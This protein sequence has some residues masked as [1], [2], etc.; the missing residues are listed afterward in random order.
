[1][2]GNERE[3]IYNYNLAGNS[4]EHTN[5]SK[6]CD[7]FTIIKTFQV[8]NSNFR[9]AAKYTFKL[10]E[11][12]KETSPEEAIALYNEAS[13]YYECHAD[14]YNIVKCQIE[15][16]YLHIKA[17][18]YSEAA[19]LFEIAGNTGSDNQLLRFKCI[20]YFMNAI[21]CFLAISDIDLA[22][23]KME[24]YS[25]TSANFKQWYR[26]VKLND[27][28]ITAQSGKLQSFV[29][30]V[31]EF[32]RQ[33]SLEQWQVEVLLMVGKAITDKTDNIL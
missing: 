1:M 15:M 12:S 31:Q 26:V 8:N 32:D 10:A 22:A 17:K 4:Y 18:R 23:I 28:I 27:I 20:E 5:K 24:I 3:Y 9:E 2:A 21:F 33:K 25:N 16:A 30:S 29:D 19:K 7:I 11:L 14:S 13:S 6:V